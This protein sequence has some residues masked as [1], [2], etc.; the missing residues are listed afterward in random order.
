MIYTLQYV[1]QNMRTQQKII[2]V[3]FVCSAPRRL[4]TETERNTM[5]VS[6]V[7]R[8]KEQVTSRD[9]AVIEVTNELERVR[10][11][12]TQINSSYQQQCQLAQRSAYALHLYF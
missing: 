10:Q 8:L 3:V 5:Y 6:E 1:F 7:S 11:Q 4:S 12:M 9:R 2:A